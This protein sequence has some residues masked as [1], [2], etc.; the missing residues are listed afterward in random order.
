LLSEF[1]KM[2]CGSSKPADVED[3]KAAVRLVCTCVYG[4][5]RGHLVYYALQKNEPRYLLNIYRAAPMLRPVQAKFPR[6]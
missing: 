4:Q 6:F 3:I 1:D 2:G 5:N